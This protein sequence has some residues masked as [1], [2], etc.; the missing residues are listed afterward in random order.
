MSFEK[1]SETVQVYDWLGL[2]PVDLDTDRT[3][4]YI[5][6]A[7]YRRGLAI[8]INAAGTAGDDW[9]FTVRQATAAAGTGVKD[10]DIIDSYL[11]KQ[12]ATNL[13]AVPTFTR[14]A[15]TADALITG[16]ATSAE[17]VCTVMADLDFSLLDTNNAFNFVSC[18]V[19]LAASGG[20]Q[21]GAVVLLLYDA[22]YPQK[23]ALG[24]QS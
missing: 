11:I 23:G 4:D 22:R 10:A 15:Q 14:T 9:L 6:V 18:T 1:M 3:G 8:F 5:N 24:A 20:A 21:Q 12:A 16:S 19:T 17:Q 13:L 7:N 2:G